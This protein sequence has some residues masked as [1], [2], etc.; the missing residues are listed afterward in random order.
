MIK[1]LSKFQKQNDFYSFFFGTTV[2]SGF[3]E[4]LCENTLLRYTDFSAPLRV[5]G[6]IIR[7]EIDFAVMVGVEFSWNSFHTSSNGFQEYGIPY[8]LTI[9]AILNS[10]VDSMSL[11]FPL[12]LKICT[13]IFYS[14][15]HRKCIGKRQV[16]S[17]FDTWC[18]SLHSY[19]FG[20]LVKMFFN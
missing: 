5:H 7:L 8:Q 10:M 11:G 18:S 15:P 1:A 16:P 3:C 20:H 12:W 13:D 19:N 14:N 9:L 2:K 6:A 17:H 4:I